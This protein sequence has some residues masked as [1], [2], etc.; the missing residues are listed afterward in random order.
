MDNLCGTFVKRNLAQK[1]KGEN[2][3][4]MQ[5]L[6]RISDA[7][8]SAKGSQTQGYSVNDPIYDIL[9]RADEKAAPWL[10][11]AGVEMGWAGI[12]CECW[13]DSMS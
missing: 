10:R 6:G 7:L 1:L 5:S 4:Y 2:Y 3:R 9:E 13:N 8:C 11:G 12:V